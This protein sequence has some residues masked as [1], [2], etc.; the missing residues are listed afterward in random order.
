MKIRRMIAVALSVVL[1]LLCTGCSAL[2][3]AFENEHIRSCTQKMVDAIIADDRQSAYTIVR[4]VSTQDT[5]GAAYSEMRELLKDVDDYE[6]RLLSINQNSHLSGGETR[7]V[8]T[9]AY[10]MTT[11]IGTFIIDVQSSDPYP[12]LTA[13]V[14]TPLEKTNYYATGGL[15]NMKDATVLQWVML[16]SNI[17]VIGVMIFAFVD[18]CRHKVKLKAL[19]L[20][21]IALGVFTVGATVSATNFRFNINFGWLTAYTALIQYG[22][23]QVML[24]FMLPIGS[25]VYLILRHWIIK[26]SAPAPELPTESDGGQEAE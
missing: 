6:L 19:W 24:R 7:T 17:L 5:F 26:R 3:Q 10:K 4:G 2:L 14:I 8:V 22:G 15:S 20:V 9:A 11:D 1:L 16:L 21:L 12:D 18:C 25:A 13:F 23:G